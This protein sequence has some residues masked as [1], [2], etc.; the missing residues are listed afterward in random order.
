MGTILGLQYILY[1]YMEL[2]GKGIKIM[3]EDLKGLG[4]GYRI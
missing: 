1:D 2:L 3:D 4:I